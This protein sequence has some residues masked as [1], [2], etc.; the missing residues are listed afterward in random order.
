MITEV[1]ARTQKNER[2]PNKGKR[3]K[4]RLGGVALRS[5]GRPSFPR[6]L[7]DVT[8]LRTLECQHCK[9]Q[10]LFAR[11]MHY[12]LPRNGV[13]HLHGRLS[14]A[15]PGEKTGPANRGRLGCS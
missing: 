12:A 4:S 2:R 8:S 11:L 14:D 3:R 6:A 15:L 7:F 5:S 9:E 1:G 13:G 10:G